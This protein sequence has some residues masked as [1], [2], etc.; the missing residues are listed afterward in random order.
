MCL[1]FL[2]VNS[3]KSAIHVISF[4]LPI[5]RW[6][7]FLSLSPSSF[8]SPSQEIKIMQKQHDFFKNFR[9]RNLLPSSV[10]T[11]QAVGHK[12]RTKC[13]CRPRPTCHMG[14]KNGEM[15]EASLP[16]TDPPWN[17]HRTSKLLEG[18]DW[19]YDISKWNQSYIITTEML[20]RN[21]ENGLWCQTCQGG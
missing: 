5:W 12:A 14:E 19:R 6:Q 8:Y 21:Q 2:F 10:L 1:L 13:A 15:M 18:K 9:V 20:A 3:W 17:Q 16:E 11:T 7:Y 4:I